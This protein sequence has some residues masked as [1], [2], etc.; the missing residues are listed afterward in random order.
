MNVLPFS[1]YIKGCKEGNGFQVLCS[2]RDE[3]TAL[4]ETLFSLDDYSD[5]RG[6]LKILR[7]RDGNRDGDCPDC[8]RQVFFNTEFT[9][10]QGKKCY[11]LYGITFEKNF[12]DLLLPDIYQ[13]FSFDEVMEHYCGGSFS[14]TE[15]IGDTS[16]DVFSL[17]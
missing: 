13:P 16:N 17:L 14:L 1:E 3:E 5:R 6:I 8:L 4:F 11:E 10:D 2:N 12:D 9:E 15:L 7:D